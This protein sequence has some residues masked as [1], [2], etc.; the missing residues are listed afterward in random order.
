[1]F[2]LEKQSSALVLHNLTIPPD[3]AAM[4]SFSDAT[5]DSFYKEKSGPQEAAQPLWVMKLC[6][7][8]NKTVS[9]TECVAAWFGGIVG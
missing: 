4:H 7:G 5:A 3:P 9:E 1:M 6:R 8:L 2:D